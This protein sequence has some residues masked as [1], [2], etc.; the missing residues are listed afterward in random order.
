MKNLIGRPFT[1]GYHPKLER[2]NKNSSFRLLHLKCMK[3]PV[4]KILTWVLRFFSAST[5]CPLLTQTTPDI[6]TVEK[7]TSALN[8]YEIDGAI[9]CSDFPY[10][11][12]GSK[13]ANNMWLTW[14]TFETE[15]SGPSLSS[16]SLLDVCRPIIRDLRPYGDL[17]LRAPQLWM[18]AK[19]LPDLWLWQ[20][21][22]LSVN[23]VFVS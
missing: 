2:Y 13:R 10:S 3:L 17:K 16:S 4:A 18:L 8:E 14:L 5:T 7:R 12:V 15:L 23:A 9:C 21:L 1:Q 19:N 11:N 6:F 20:E 22:S